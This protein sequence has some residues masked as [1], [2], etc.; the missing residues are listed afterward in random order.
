VSTYLHF[1]AKAFKRNLA[2][3]AQVWLTIL[4]NLLA[5][6]IQV[7]IW[8]ALLGQGS[9]SGINIRDMVTYVILNAAIYVVMMYEMF[10]SVDDR[11]RTGDIAIDLMKPMRYP[12]FLWADQLGNAAYRLLFSVTP[13][14]VVS[15]VLFG[16]TPPASLDNAAG[17][18]IAM[19]I[20]VIMSFA[21]AYL[22]ALLAFH[23]LTT[24]HFEWT[25]FGLATVFSGRLLPLWFFPQGWADLAHAL[26]FQFLGFVPAAIYMG[27]IQGAEMWLTLG[28]GLVWVVVLLAL[29][30]SMWSISIRRLV[31][32]GG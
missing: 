7:S 18:V 4:I 24:L 16:F 31:V 12:L 25:F 10:Q 26:P 15:A 27:K 13:T 2:Y 29:A 6:V 20:A 28:L 22:I 11:L 30:A 23:F 17:F 8:R 1:L 21:F 14:V 3:R 9:A 32:Q 19:A 5:I